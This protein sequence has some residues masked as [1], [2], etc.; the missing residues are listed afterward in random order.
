MLQT[1]TREDLT[2]GPT[3]DKST[4][5][6]ATA[7]VNWLHMQSPDPDILRQAVLEILADGGNRYLLSPD[8]EEYPSD[9]WLEVDSI[10]TPPMS[11]S[12]RIII[13]AAQRVWLESRRLTADDLLNPAN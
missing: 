10:D 9:E 13:D 7:Q 2:P 5:T 1:L 11:P 3:L 4:D 8:I 12:R 6:E